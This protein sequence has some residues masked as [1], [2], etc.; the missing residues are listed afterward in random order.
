MFGLGWAELLVIAFVGLLLFGN[1]LPAVARWLGKTFVEIK[2]ETDSLTQD[3][4]SPINK[5]R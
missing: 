3:V 1:Q 2:K 5:G 4:R